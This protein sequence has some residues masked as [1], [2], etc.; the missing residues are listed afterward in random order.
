MRWTFSQADGLVQIHH[1]IELEF[2]CLMVVWHYDWYAPKSQEHDH[3]RQR[4]SFLIGF[5]TH[6][7]NIFCCVVVMLLVVI[8]LKTVGP[9]K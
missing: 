5:A 8:R 7:G 9:C 6:H 4:R 2:G 1:D 3:K